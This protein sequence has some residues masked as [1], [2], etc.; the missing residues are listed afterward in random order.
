MDGMDKRL[1]QKARQS[2]MHALRLVVVRLLQFSSRLARLGHTHKQT[3]FKPIK[4]L[5]L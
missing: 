4:Q 2:S 5:E 1:V 3:P